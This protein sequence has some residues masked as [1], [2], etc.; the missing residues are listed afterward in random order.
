MQ[1][2]YAAGGSNRRAHAA[3]Q[4]LCLEGLCLHAFRKT[5][6]P[7]CTTSPAACF[8]Q[9]GG[10]NHLPPHEH[11]QL[12]QTRCKPFSLCL[13]CVPGPKA[14]THTLH[15]ELPEVGCKPH[16]PQD[17]WR[18]GKTGQRACQGHHKSNTSC[19][20][21]HTNPTTNNGSEKGPAPTTTR[22]LR[23]RCQHQQGRE[24]FVTL[25][26]THRKMLSILCTASRVLAQS[27]CPTKQPG[28]QHTSISTAAYCRIC[29]AANNNS[30]VQPRYLPQTRLTQPCKDRAQQTLCMISLQT[31]VDG[32]T[33]GVHTQTQSHDR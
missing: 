24:C 19:L 12:Q 4:Y 30:T 31:T 13:S 33:T 25:T 26:Q 23:G 21:Q 8:F 11:Q 22:W 9:H 18:L 1:H 16:F 27:T 17:L 5:H 6:I 20:A 15:C 10:T 32:I 3:M 29:R 28:F 7:P 2:A 14:A